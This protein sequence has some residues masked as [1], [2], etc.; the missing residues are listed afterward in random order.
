MDTNTPTAVPPA[1]ETPILGEPL[2]PLPPLDLS[3]GPPTPTPAVAQN[4]V[5]SNIGALHAETTQIASEIHNHGLD[6]KAFANAL[7]QVK[8]Y[9]PGSSARQRSYF[10]FDDLWRIREERQ[11]EIAQEF[12]CDHS[13]ID[14]LRT[15][16]SRKRVLILTGELR[17]GKTT[18]AIFVAQSIIK[19]ARI[20]QSEEKDA[21]DSPL[22]IYVVPP[23]NRNVVINLAE[24]CK[25]GDSPAS[26]FVIFEDAFSGRNEDLA[27]FLRQ[28][29]ESSLQEFA[30]H[31][32]EQ[33]SYLIFTAN[34]SE[35]SQLQLSAFKSSLRYELKC[36]SA[37]LLVSGIRQRL[38]AL[39][40]RQAINA[41]R[42]ATLQTSVS[43]QLIISELKTMPEIVEFLGEY[44]SADEELELSEAIRRY[45]SIKDWFRHELEPDFD[46]WCFALSL[47][48]AHWSGKL[49][50]VSWFDF[51]YIRRLVWFCLR[52]DQELFPQKIGQS[53]STLGEI[54]LRAPALTDDTLETKSRA[55][56]FKDRNDLA[57]QIGFNHEGY[58][59]KLW[60]TM[61]THYRRVLA[62][63]LERLRAVAQ[64]RETDYD[65]R[66]LCAQI[67]GRIGEIDPERI[68]LSVL[69]SW[70]HSGEVPQ[71]AA[72]AGLYEGIL[73][74]DNERYKQY[75]LALLAALTVIDDDDKQEKHRILTAIAVYARIGDYDPLLSMKGL[76]KIVQ[77]KLVPAMTDAQ[78]AERLLQNTEKYF[79]KE[80]SKDQVVD[81]LQYRKMLRDFA[82]RMYAQQ[83]STFVGVQ[84]ALSSLAVTAGP[85]KIFRELRKW[86]ESSNRETGALIATMFLF[87]DGIAEM[88]SAE[89]VQVSE[90]AG[91]KSEKAKTCSLVVESLTKGPETVVEMARFLVTLYESFEPHFAYPRKFTRYL[92]ES[93]ISQLTSWVDETI[94]IQSCR[95]ALAALFVE[96]MRIRNGVL[97]DVLYRLLTSSKFLEKK[98]E[99][100][101]EFVDAVLWKKSNVT[102]SR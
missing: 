76:E 77:I 49:K 4:A 70:I 3:P 43:E 62:I 8:S 71:R 102:D 64:N 28:L 48:L 98:P 9:F 96:M 37:D 38:E 54:S 20:C 32:A 13:E 63:L 15:L 25:N 73:A 30:N 31:L 55:R 44:L 65:R 80:L 16:I 53:D 58:A 17:L 40:A 19:E 10:K 66:D 67:I 60:A 85:I 92:V 36:L 29:N 46:A 2:P 101:K 87:E 52:R 84:F 41:E 11:A 69:N 81:L 51:E 14:R 94:E 57:D 27:G 78:R 33:N 34:T 5:N 24:L 100:K 86:I 26:R 74:S 72:V 6:E 88:L 23:L 79:E 56:V 97:F 89:K 12:I 90:E 59:Q 61:L 50:H 45:Q 1:L 42:L 21:H 83:G 18:T 95:R 47:G 75:F 7:E 39:T 93:F 82:Q 91:N 22:E 68:T 35:A 99:L